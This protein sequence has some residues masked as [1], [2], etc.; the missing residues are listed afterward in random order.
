MWDRYT[1]RRKINSFSR[2]AGWTWAPALPIRG[3]IASTSRCN[4]RCRTCFLHAPGTNYTVEDMKPEVYERVRRQL[5]PALQEVYLS[6]AGEPFLAPIFY[7]ILS[8]ILDLGKR[9]TVVTNGTI[10]RPEYLERLV[11]APSVIAVSLDGTTPEV[12]D[13]I[14]PG[15]KLDRVL[16]FMKTIKEMM[17]RGA[18]SAFELQISFVVTRSNLEQLTDCV[19]LARR[20]GVRTI[21]FTSFLAAGRDDDFA[22]HESLMNQPELVLPHWE[23]AWKRGIELGINIPPIVF[24][25]RDRSEAEQRKWQPTLYDARG[26]IRQCP[27]PWWN[28][29]IEADGSVRPC[30]IFPPVGNILEAPFREIW[31]GPGYRELRAKVNTSDMPHHCRQCFMAVRI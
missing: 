13:L 4:L 11:R 28:T 24:D 30:C 22:R 26:R 18:H 17:D 7:E 12:M 27:I 29:Y 19:E 16:D 1:I 25:C 6:G 23:R 10:S 14:R 31:N 15:A 5:L 2:R 8:D 9:V 3:W 20:F 21:A